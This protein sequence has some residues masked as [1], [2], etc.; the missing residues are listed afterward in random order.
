RQQFPEMA[1]HVSTQATVTGALGAK[2]YEKIGV[3]RVVPARE[4]DLNEIKKIK[5]ETNLE[6]ECFVHGALCYCYSGQCLFSSLIGGRSG[7]RG[8]CAQ[9]C[10]LSFSINKK[11]TRDFLSLK[12]LCTIENIPDLIDAGIDSFK[13]EGRMK[14]PQY[15]YTVVKMYRKYVDL[16]LLYGKNK[17]HVSREDIRLLQ[18]VYQRR[19]YTDGYYFRHNGKEMLSLNQPEYREN[20]SFHSEIL[21]MKMQ[22]KINGKLILKKEE[23]AKLSVEYHGFEVSVE[24]VVVQKALNQPLGVDRIEKQV[25]KTGESDFIFEKLLIFADEDIFLSMKSINELRRTALEKLKESI[26]RCYFRKVPV[27]IQKNE[28]SYGTVEDSKIS[29]RRNPL[30]SVMIS[31]K[32][33]LKQVIP[34]ESI[35][36]IYIDCIHLMKDDYE[37]IEWINKEK[38][39]KKIVLVMP[40]IFRESA[41]KYFEK[42]YSWIEEYFDGIMIRNY[43][44]YQWLLEKEFR[45]EIHADTGVY[46]WNQWDKEMAVKYG[47]QTWTAPVEFNHKELKELDVTSGCLLVYGY[48]PLMITAN[49]IQNT[50]DRCTHKEQWIHMKDRKQA[51]FPVYNCCKYCY[52]VIYNSK[53]LMLH[54]EKAEIDKLS[55]K[56]IRID[57]R[58]ES[59][60][61]VCEILSLY[62]DTFINHNI[63]SYKE[64]DFTKGHF[65][66]GVK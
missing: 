8:Q 56:Q 46:L 4:L 37:F 10:R 18:S 62:Q 15:V 1:V 17:F 2:F 11:K 36:M 35:D 55:P 53:P 40:Y 51:F 63:R 48:L 14:Q 31:T 7:N 38:K 50:M 24:G 34:F 43:E 66:R 25:R 52:N 12:D 41:I 39:A 60:E 57:F 16:Y 42:I 21:D 6:V 9:P 30:F 19:G 27:R 22:E 20:E 13:I 45:K 65:R 54:S 64:Y 59:N 3:T 44:E 49:C 33:Q 32:E 61:E 58:F 26:L 5:Q 47:I 29:D 28:Y 23:S